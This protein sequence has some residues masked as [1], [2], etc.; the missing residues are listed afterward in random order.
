MARYNQFYYA[1]ALYGLQSPLGF[2]AEPMSANAI[3]YGRVVVS[4]TSPVGVYEG[5]RIV[6]NQEAYPLSQ[7]DGFTVLSTTG[8]VRPVG[9][10]VI[11]DQTSEVPLVGGRF[12][13]YRAW[14]RKGT[15]ADWIPVGSAYTV[16]PKSNTLSLPVDTTYTK[17]ATPSKDGFVNNLGDLTLNMSTT[18]ERFISLL[19]AVLT[20]TTNSPLD[21]PENVYNSTY[22]GDY[23]GLKSNSLLSTFLSGFSY[24]VDEFLTMAELI[25]PDNPGHGASPSV[26]ALRSHELGVTQDVDSVTVSQKKLLRSA[27]DIYQTKG[28][29]AGLETYVKSITDFDVTISDLQNNNLLLS[30]ED[31]TFDIEGWNTGDPVGRWAVASGSAT[32]SV[33]TS[34]DLP[35]V[36]SSL[37]YS[38]DIYPAI[39]DNTV[40][41]KGL[42]AMQVEV[43][44][45]GTAISLGANSPVTDGIP[46]TP[47]LV[48]SKISKTAG[49]TATVTITTLYS[50]GLNTGDI[51]T[52]ANLVNK[53]GALISELNKS[54]ATI[55]VT[56]EFTFTYG[57]SGVTTTEIVTTE[58]GTA[59]VASGIVITPFS[60][61]SLGFWAKVGTSGNITPSIKWFNRSGVLISTSSPSAITLSTSWAQKKYENV[62]VP[63]GAYYA[64]ISMTFSANDT[65]YLDSIQFEK[66]ATV[67]TYYEPRGVKIVLNPTKTNFALNP[68]FESVSEGVLTSWAGSG[69]TFTQSADKNYTGGDPVVPGHSGKIVATADA[70]MYVASNGY[71]FDVTAG[72]SYS[73][74][75]WTMWNSSGKGKKVTA[76]I[77][78]YGPSGSTVLSTLTGT[79]TIVTDAW[80]R[81]SVS[82]VAPSGATRAKMFI[83]TSTATLTNDALYVDAAQ[84]E[85]A[86]YPTDY[87]DGTATIFRD[88]YWSA[89]VGTTS[90]Y[91]LGGSNKIARLQQE[92]TE[93]LPYDTP[94]YIEFAGSANYPRSLSGIA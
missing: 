14:L 42:H 50:H 69:G 29:M 48:I 90:Y 77:K 40:V 10:Y 47:S 71:Y 92:V 59:K 44:S 51:V 38:L 36:A 39:V 11:D 45:V 75:A 54:N 41:N 88:T 15:S 1:T 34:G 91:Y 68:N 93:Y 76:Q 70:S 63:S 26:V 7:E 27:V 13:Y 65:Y 24:T 64:V 83:V 22:T 82:G 6:R 72:Q 2:S 79:E 8:G 87:F 46:V 73:A 28:T 25:Q 5:F 23:T 43:S 9:G 58:V 3:N 84:F 4:Y 18:H 74:S 35:A 78:F 52:I 32:L 67:G 53:S 21:Q 56:G 66:S 61:Y 16:I 94:Y 55:T 12:V 57:V 60:I 20:S 30:H 86:P 81:V 80:T 49:T 37:P 19:P 17:L 31:A 62:A 89:G 85:A 33:V